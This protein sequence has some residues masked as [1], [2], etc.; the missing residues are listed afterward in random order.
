MS[1]RILVSLGLGL[2]ASA[3]AAC[4]SAEVLPAKGSPAKG[5]ASGTS[6]AAAQPAAAPQG[7]AVN[8][9]TSRV[10][11]RV[12]KTGLGHVHGVVGNLKSGALTLGARSGAGQVV[13]DMTSF[14]AD[15]DEARKYVGLE[16]QTDAGT[17]KKVNDNMLGASVL[18]V[19]AHPTA[20]F[21]VDSALET[22]KRT[23]AGN[24]LYELKGRF[25]LHGTTPPLVVTAEA[26]PA[27]KGVRLRGKFKVLQTQFGIT[28]YTAALGAVGVADELTIW[29]DLEINP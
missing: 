14:V 4:W 13:F 8:L 18:D 10:Y 5:P 15:T 23:T 2:A 16:G 9:K 20:T 3:A 7:P 24:P 1:R 25:T 29:G 22:G 17:Q 21:D 11:V 26:A 28:P 19:K 6:A 12:E 27:A